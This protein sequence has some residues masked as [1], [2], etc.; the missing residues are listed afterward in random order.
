MAK[1][2]ENAKFNLAKI[3]P[4]KVMSDEIDVLHIMNN[5]ERLFWMQIHN[6]TNAE[7]RYFSTEVK[8]SRIYNEP[9]NLF[10][11]EKQINFDI[12]LL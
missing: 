5:S 10:C 2:R 6:F 12:R 4:I 3:N 1:I 11:G 9:I 7:N 8:F